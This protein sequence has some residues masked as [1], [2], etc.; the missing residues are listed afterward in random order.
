MVT[1]SINLLI[2]LNFRFQCF[3]SN[4][5]ESKLVGRSTHNQ[6]NSALNKF[7]ISILHHCLIHTQNNLFDFEE[8]N[9]SRFYLVMKYF[10]FSSNLK[11]LINSANTYNGMPNRQMFLL[12][13]DPLMGL[14]IYFQ[15]VFFTYDNDK[16]KGR[17]IDEC[18]LSIESLKGKWA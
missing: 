18:Q 8:K 2:R 6:S 13:N 9:H 11:I 12:M 15:N 10:L 3:H 7:P 16:C 5:I 1:K 4:S 14:L 17:K